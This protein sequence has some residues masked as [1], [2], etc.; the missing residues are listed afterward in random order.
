MSEE[1]EIVEDDGPLG[2]T[3]AQEKA[4]RLDAQG[5]ARSIIAK[6]CEV[7]RKTVSVWR[8]SPTYK[9]E[10]TRIRSEMSEQL[11]AQTVNTK[12]DLLGAVN[13]AIEALRLALKAERDDGSPEWGTRARAAEA[14]L[15]KAK[16]V[17]DA[18]SGND[19]GHVAQ[20][21]VIIVQQG[22]DGGTRIIEGTTLD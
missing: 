7:S 22:S 8:Q 5:E 3:G 2:L 18:D 15:G 19:S 11:T 9:S 1:L 14:L 13:E 16:F 20:A 6:R 4:A 10:V 12:L 17:Y 21:A